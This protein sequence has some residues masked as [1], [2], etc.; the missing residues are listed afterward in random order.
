MDALEGVNEKI[1]KRF[2]NPKLSNVHCA[3]VCKHAALAWCRS[4][5]TKLASITPLPLDVHSIQSVAQSVGNMDHGLQLVVDIQTDELLNI[6]YEDSNLQSKLKEKLHPLL[7]RIRNMPIKHATAEN[8]DIAVKM[9]HYAF[10]FYRESSCGALPSGINMCAV[11]SRLHLQGTFPSTGN[12]ELAS[13]AE[14][15]DLSMPRKL[16]LWA[17]TLAHGRYCNIQAV[18]KHCEENA[19]VVNLMLTNAS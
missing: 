3:R 14:V 18:V 7:S 11:P 16:L 2:K 19:K 10:N 1:R 17:Y 6:S 9:L 5:L 12:F 8:M 13:T 15:L 4:I